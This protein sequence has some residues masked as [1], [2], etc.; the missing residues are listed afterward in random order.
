MIYPEG[1]HFDSMRLKK[2]SSDYTYQYILFVIPNVKSDMNLD[3][4]NLNILYYDQN[5]KYYTQT[6]VWE[7]D[8]QDTANRVMA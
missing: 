1:T 7:N 3:S 4:P 8:A 2:N 6:N 5:F